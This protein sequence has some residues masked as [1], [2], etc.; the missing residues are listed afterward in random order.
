MSRGYASSDGAQYEYSG[1]DGAQPIPR[2]GQQGT[3]VF[4]SSGAAASTKSQ[5]EYLLPRPPSTMISK[6]SSEARATA[7]SAVSAKLSQRAREA[8]TPASQLSGCGLPRDISSAYRCSL[9]LVVSIQFVCGASRRYFRA[10][11]EVVRPMHSVEVR[12]IL[13]LSKLLHCIGSLPSGG[14]NLCS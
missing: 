1:T 4:S 10:H 12:W 13:T 2:S 14:G 11:T 7:P 6:T 3:G 5:A 9:S 8:R